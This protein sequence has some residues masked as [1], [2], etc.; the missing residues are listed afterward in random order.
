MKNKKVLWFL[1]FLV[2]AAISCWATASSFHLMMPSM[3][4]LAVWGMTVVFFCFASFAV[5]WIVDSLNND[6][7]LTHP[8]VMLWGGL[9]ILF[10]TWV[11][12]SLPT[13]AHTF[14]Y[15]LKIGDVVTEDLKTTKVYSEQIANRTVVDSAYLEKYSKIMS[16]WE[17]FYNQAAFGRSYNSVE[18]ASG[19]GKFANEYITKLNEELGKDGEKY[20][21]DYP[22][23]TNRAS[24]SE[25][26]KILNRVKTELSQKLDELKSDIYQVP[27][28]ASTE[29]KKDVNRIVAMEDSVH[30]LILT[31]QISEDSA[32]PII[33]QSAGVLKVAYANI[34]NSSKF[35]KFNNKDEEKLYTAAN[36][37]TKTT[38]FLNPYSV[39]HDFF[40]GKIPF[41]FTFWLLL[42]ILIDIS[43]F[44]FY[45]QATKRHYNF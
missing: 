15:K 17:Q 36:I 8:K 7:S 1:G 43:G 3:P 5:K 9:A 35:V 29:A 39:T 37:E 41:T 14:F 21:V 19:I 10:F 25:I 16:S 22:D 6:G 24:Q 23:L 4:I 2:V 28:E 32:E 26:V 34:K 12:I 13:N 31:N 44:F 40:T 30:Q 38:R 33:T 45:Y 27:L 11:I 18:G 42:S 20:K